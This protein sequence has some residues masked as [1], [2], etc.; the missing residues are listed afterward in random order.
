MPFKKIY[1][2]DRLNTRMTIVVKLPILSSLIVVFFY[3]MWFFFPKSRLDF[4]SVTITPVNIV[5]TLNMITMRMKCEYTCTI[6]LYYI[7]VLQ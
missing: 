6:V 3:F 1:P 7:I 5:I 2:F 4:Q